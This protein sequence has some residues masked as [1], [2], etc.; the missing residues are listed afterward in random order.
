MTKGGPM[1]P[2][3]LR[4]RKLLE[5][6]N[7]DYLYHYIIRKQNLYWILGWAVCI[8]NVESRNKVQGT[9]NGSRY[10]D[11]AYWYEP[12]YYRDTY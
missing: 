10:I 3:G 12:A 8:E 2:V 5:F 6:D 9:D 4:I 1:E 7:I 11:R